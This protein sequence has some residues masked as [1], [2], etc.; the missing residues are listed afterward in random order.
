MGSK[1]AF[2]SPNY[3]ISLL[4][5][6]SSRVLSFLRA[7]LACQD[8]WDDQQLGL[9]FNEP[10]EVMPSTSRPAQTDASPTACRGTIRSRHKITPPIIGMMG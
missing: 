5:W 4:S 7:T 1:K 10:Q 9:P 6:S 2:D 8:E 3:S